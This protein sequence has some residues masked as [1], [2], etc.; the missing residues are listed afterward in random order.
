MLDNTLD[1]ILKLES[2]LGLY[3]PELLAG[4]L[5]GHHSGSQ[6][7]TGLSKSLTR[8]RKVEMVNIWLSSPPDD[9]KWGAP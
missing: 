2:M 4:K 3:L 7:I 9:S 1:R 8:E 5:F 6:V